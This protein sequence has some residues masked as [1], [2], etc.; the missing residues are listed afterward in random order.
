ME[1]YGFKIDEF[2]RSYLQTCLW[3][4]TDGE[5]CLDRNHDFSHLSREFVERAHK[6][7]ASFQDRNQH[8]LRGESP[9]RAGHDFWLTRNRHGAGFWDGDYEEDKGKRLTAVAEQYG[10]VSVYVG[11]DGLIYA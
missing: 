8:D 9:N 4:E 6:D 5:E 2:T 10:E 3:T 7:C 11:D 1:L